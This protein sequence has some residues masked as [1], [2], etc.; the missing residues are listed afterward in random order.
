MERRKRD[1]E[2]GNKED[3]QLCIKPERDDLI[4]NKIPR[5]RGSREFSMP[6]PPGPGIRP[7]AEHLAELQCMYG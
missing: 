7:S 1:K 6:V 4:G 5:T 2:D 3:T